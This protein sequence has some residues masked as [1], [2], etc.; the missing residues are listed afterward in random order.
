MEGHTKC[1]KCN[2][3]IENAK[4]DRHNFIGHSPAVE[5]YLKLLSDSLKGGKTDGKNVL[6]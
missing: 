2:H 6:Q 4:W 1:T 3:W 5:G